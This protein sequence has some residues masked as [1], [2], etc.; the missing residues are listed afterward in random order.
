MILNAVGLQV[1]TRLPKG[2]SAIDNLESA[3]DKDAIE[4]MA[5]MEH[6]RWHVERLMQGWQYAPEKDEEARTHFC[7][8]SWQQLPEKYQQY[9]VDAV[10]EFPSVLAKAGLLIYSEDSDG[11]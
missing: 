11:G 5:M 4:R 9:N 8:V 10:L 7:M 6:G 2:G 1:G 3:L